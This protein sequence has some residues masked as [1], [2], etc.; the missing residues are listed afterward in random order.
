[1]KNTSGTSVYKKK[2]AFPILVS[3]QW[4]QLLPIQVVPGSAVGPQLLQAYAMIRCWGAVSSTWHPL[5]AGCESPTVCTQWREIS[6]PRSESH[7]ARPVSPFTYCVLF[8]LM[9]RVQ[10]NAR[11]LHIL[12]VQ[13]LYTPTHN[14]HQNGTSEGHCPQSFRY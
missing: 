3:L 7:P 6:R 4:L 1:M 5:S 11:H 2:C 8:W 12:R 10:N 14:L 9:I 13:T